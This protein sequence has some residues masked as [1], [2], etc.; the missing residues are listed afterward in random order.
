M[1]QTKKIEEIKK[2]QVEIHPCQYC[3]KPCRGKQCKE[4]H[5][6]MVAKKQGKCIDCNQVFLAARPDGTMR[7]RCLNCQNAYKEKHIACCPGCGE[8][9]HAF[10]DDGRVYKS[11]FKCY[12]A[13]FSKCEREGCEK[14][15]FEGYPFCGECYQEERKKK[16]KEASFA[17]VCKK[18]GCGKKTDY[19]FCRECNNERKSLSETYM[20][21]MCTGCGVRIKGDYKKCYGCNNVG[22]K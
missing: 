14:R 2:E 13:S 6:K 16:D 4:C 11:C 7:K 15:T 1:E 17:N 20:T 19:T 22:R 5:L 3:E 8:D 10:L 18:L 21:S 9:F 12:E